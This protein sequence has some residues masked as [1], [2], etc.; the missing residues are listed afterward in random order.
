MFIIYWIFSLYLCDSTFVLAKGYKWLDIFSQRIK[1]DIEP[2][3]VRVFMNKSV[4]TFSQGANVVLQRLMEIIPVMVID[5]SIIQNSSSNISSMQ[6]VI[7]NSTGIGSTIFLHDEIDGQYDMKVVY[8]LH[9]FDKLF[10]VSIRPKFLLIHFNEGWYSKRESLQKVLEYGWYNKYLHFSIL[11]V[12]WETKDPFLYYLNPFYKSLHE[13]ILSY[14]SRL[15]PAMLRNLNGYPIILPIFQY[16]S[17]MNFSEENGKKSINSGFYYDILRTALEAMNFTLNF[18]EIINVSQAK[19][20]G[21]IFRNLKSGFMNIMT[22][23]CPVS[24]YDTQLPFLVLYDDCFRYVGL[25]KV[26]PIVDFNISSDILMLIASIVVLVVWIKRII[27]VFNLTFYNFKSLEV[28]RIFIGVPTMSVPKNSIKRLIVIVAGFLSIGFWITFT[29]DIMVALTANGEQTFHSVKEIDESEYKV[30]MN[31]VVYNITFNF[32][33]E[34]QFQNIKKKITVMEIREC[35]KIVQEHEKTI[36]ILSFFRARSELKNYLNMENV[37]LMKIAYVNFACV[38]LAYVFEKA[39]PYLTGVDLILKR[40]HQSGIYHYL[41][42]QT[43]I[44]EKSDNFEHQIMVHKFFLTAIVIIL[45]A[46]Y[47]FSLIIL[48]VELLVHRIR[49]NSHALK[50]H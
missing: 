46:G 6:K 41:L 33:E 50:S 29:T 39:S 27:S 18:I 22:V 24:Y 49:K 2:F 4:G 17:Y 32:N 43:Q 26:E 31:Q 20:Y 25:M 37:K 48:I 5:L 3:D 36:C 11:E 23:P 19:I 38:K 15:F 13:N 34:E 16:A 45:I 42:K 35:A 1:K 40:L 14:H 8:F 47:V 7:P 12:P 44:I 9:F 10:P 30:V 21:N 28:F